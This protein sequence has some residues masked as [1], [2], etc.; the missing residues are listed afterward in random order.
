VQSGTLSLANA[1]AIDKNVL[2]ACWRVRVQAGLEPGAAPAPEIIN[3]LPAFLDEMIALLQSHATEADGWN[4]EKAGA[5]AVTHGAQRFHSG[6]SLGAVVR[7]YGILRECLLDFVRDH[8]ISIAVDELRAVLAMLNSGL[9]NAAEQFTRERDQAIERQSE[10]HLGFIAH[11]LRTPLTSAMLAAH[12]LVRR[13]GAEG[14]VTLQRLVRQ[15]SA[16][17]QRIDNSL[18]RVRIRDLERRHTVDAKPMSLRALVNDVREELVGDAEERAIAIHVDGDAIAPVDPRLVHSAIANLVGNA[19]KYTRRGGMIRV[20]VRATDQLAS[21]EV[22]DECGGLPD[23]KAEEL[24]TPF[25]QRGADR[26]GFGLG[27]AIA[28]DAVEAH[29]GS[30]QVANLPGRGCV[31]MLTVPRS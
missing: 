16:L 21:V 2:I 17:R 4:P 6:F 14:D 19:L 11:E 30:V 22:E 5:I 23:G 18:V 13:P 7:E 25:V 3:T 27:L 1:L 20:R 26:S 31:F 10:Q 12:A 28:K 15:L 24:F 9:A 8:G 29:R